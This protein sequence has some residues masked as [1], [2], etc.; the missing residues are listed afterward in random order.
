MVQW[1]L[2]CLVSCHTVAHPFRFACHTSE[3]IDRPYVRNWFVAATLASQ[4]SGNRTPEC[5][6][7]RN[8]DTKTKLRATI[9]RQ[10]EG[11]G[12]MGMERNGEQGGRLQ[13]PVMKHFLFRLSSFQKRFVLGS[14]L[15]PQVVCALVFC[16]MHQQLKHEWAH[17]LTAGM[18]WGMVLRIGFYLMMV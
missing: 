7:S 10:D 16:P 2:V 11:S 13:H 5:L 17:R 12:R 15:H 6:E 3:L 18:F 14:Q 9:V 1:C 8:W 4:H